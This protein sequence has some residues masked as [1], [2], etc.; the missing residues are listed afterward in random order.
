MND[1]NHTSLQSCLRADEC[2]ECLREEIARLRAALE[3]ADR[4]AD[5]SRAWHAYEPT[6]ESVEAL[7]EALGLYRTARAAL[8]G[9]N[10]KAA[11]LAEKKE[12]A[13]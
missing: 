10:E 2:A 1:C 5:C 4:L 11:P 9:A 7:Y 6:E 13:P 12:E 8:D 3:A